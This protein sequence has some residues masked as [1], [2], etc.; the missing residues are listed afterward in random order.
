LTLVAGYAPEARNRAVL[1]LTGM[2]A[3]STGED[4]VLC[5]V[6]PAPWPPS[7]ARVDAEYRA[8]LEGLAR[9]ALDHGRERVPADLPVTTVVE[10]ARSAPAGLQEVA[11]RAGA[12]A[13]VAG[14]G[15]VA[16]GSVSA[17]LL[18]GAEVS[19]ALAPHGFRARP[20]ERVT[21]VTVAFGGADDGLVAAAAARA[22][23]VGAKLRVAAFVV[24]PHPPYTA[25]VGR[26]ADEAMVRE[27]IADVERAAWAALD[28]VG[29]LPDVPH[30]VEVAVGRGESWEAALDDVEWR[31]GDVLVVGSSQSAPAARVFL[32]SRAARIVRAS[33]VPVIVAPR[34][35]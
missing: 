20:D 32:G 2:L 33:P 16:L 30:E 34:G 13:I 21:R 25:G 24:R 35:S 11:R 27:W 29:E 3:R 9:D 4:V 28:R 6:V 26:E 1:E 10:H 18:H 15:R 23:E 12:H 22:A 5:A 8:Y 31:D 19:V 7:P 17:R 14:A